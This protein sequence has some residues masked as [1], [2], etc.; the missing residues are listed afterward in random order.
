MMT[1]LDLARSEAVCLPPLG[2]DG[3][4]GL[5]AGRARG[6]VLF[7]HCG[8]T[9]ANH[10]VAAELRKAG[11][12]TLLFDLLSDSEAADGA[13]AFDIPLL[14][15]RVIEATEWARRFDETP[16][17]PIGYFGAGT[18]AAAALTAAARLAG[19]IA[20]VVS[21]GGR[22][23]LAASAL[24]HVFTPTLLIVGGADREALASNRSALRQL[25]WAAKLEVL[26]DAGQ[27]G[28]ERGATLARRWFIDHLAETIAWQRV[29]ALH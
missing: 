25:R 15:T 10:R 27:P 16:D 7:A 8:G 23:D 9:P 2:L 1:S 19:E 11:L 18:G 6:M 17:F 4:L 29:G 26:P 22:P 20:A 13:A 5:P 14:A 3:V 21:C 12:A 28:E 24:S